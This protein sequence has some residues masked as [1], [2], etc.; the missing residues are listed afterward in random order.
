MLLISIPCAFHVVLLEGVSKKQSVH[1]SMKWMSKEQCTLLA[2]SLQ[3]SSSLLIHFV[4]DMEIDGLFV[5]HFM[6]KKRKLRLSL[7]S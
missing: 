5:D 7:V 1:S 2:D 3:N 4:E 6:K